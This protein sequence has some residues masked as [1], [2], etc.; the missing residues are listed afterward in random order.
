MEKRK[1]EAFLFS[2]CLNPAYFFFLAG[3]GGGGGLYDA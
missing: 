3:G 2:G 1:V